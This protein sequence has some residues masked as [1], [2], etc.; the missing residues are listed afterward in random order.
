MDVTLE[1]LYPS[2]TSKVTTATN[3][4]PLHSTPLP[5]RKPSGPPRPESSM[6]MG[7]GRAMHTLQEGVSTAAVAALSSVSEQH[8]SHQEPEWTAPPPERWGDD[9]LLMSG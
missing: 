4:I 7:L 5:Q 2:N 1:P 3:L 9:E 8:H 6:D